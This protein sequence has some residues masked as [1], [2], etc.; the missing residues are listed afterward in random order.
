[1]KKYVVLLFLF[2]N[3]GMVYAQNDLSLETTKALALKNN[4][5]LQNSSIELDTSRD[6]KNAAV[7][8]FFPNISAT[9]GIFQAASPLMNMTVMPGFTLGLMNSGTFGMVNVMQPIFA[10]GRIVNGNKLADLGVSV[11]QYKFDLAK[12]EVLFKTEEQYW[13]IVALKEKMKTLLTYQNLLNSLLKQVQEAKASGLV[14]KNDV[15]KVKL[16]QSELQMNKTK[17]ESG[18]KLASM[19]LCQY[20][21][22]NYDPTIQLS[23]KLSIQSVEI[24]DPQVALKN[25]DE[26]RLLQAGVDAS[27]LQSQMQLGEYMPQ[28]GVG[29]SGVLLKL[30]SNTPQTDT[31]VYGSVNIPIS[32]WWTASFKMAEQRKKEQIAKNN[33][34]DMS[35]LLVLQIQ[36]VQQDLTDSINQVFLSEEAVQQAEENLKVNQDS[37]KNGMSSISDLLEA[38]AMLQ[39]TCDQLTEAKAK[40]QIARVN[41]LQVTGR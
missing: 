7:T 28:V 1:M 33:L 11:N 20:V 35:E 26:Y 13:Q 16:K 37:Y 9:G 34:K 30:D 32:D 2:L 41:Y 6:T 38:Q 12:N 17:L 22:L 3:I 39:Q 31:V 40:Y 15:L 29:V 10:G 23:S 18:I 21:G 4:V 8:K 19:A 5:K 14:M 27:V 24:I 25:R 36:K